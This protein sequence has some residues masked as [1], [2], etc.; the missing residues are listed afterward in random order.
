MTDKTGI[1]TKTAAYNMLDAGLEIATVEKALKELNTPAA[2]YYY[3]EDVNEF[4]TNNQPK[5]D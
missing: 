1:S 2:G 4:I 5:K 3:A